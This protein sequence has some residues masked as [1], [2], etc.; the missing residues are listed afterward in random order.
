MEA[1]I[2][3]RMTVQILSE[4]FEKEIKSMKCIVKLLEKRLDDSEKKVEISM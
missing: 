2:N 1:K 4:E 3:G